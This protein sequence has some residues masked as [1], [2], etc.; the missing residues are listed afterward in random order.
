MNLSINI[1]MELCARARAGRQWPEIGFSD[2]AANLLAQLLGISLK[3]R[4]SPLDERRL[5]QRSKWFDECCRDFFQRHPLAMCI[6]L[7]AGLSTRFH[8]LSD[9]SDWPRFQWVEVDLPQVSAMKSEVLPA[10][11][12]YRL[13]SADI[14]EDDWLSLS[15]WKPEQPLLVLLESVAP[16]LKANAL[17]KLI[18][19]LGKKAGPEKLQLVLD[20]QNQPAWLVWIK[21]L[22][23]RC[24]LNIKLPITAHLS[25]LER[26]GFHVVRQ[27]SFF[28]NAVVGLVLHHE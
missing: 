20:D 24:G 15:G 16:E 27:K 17:L 21:V 22:A 19:K 28:G 26:Q 1:R 2:R 23:V 4:L 10:I 6:E 7:G 8:R 13:V 25:R 5:I 12:N 3:Q 18:E 9:T 14:A 11:D